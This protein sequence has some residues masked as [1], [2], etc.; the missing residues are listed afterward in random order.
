MTLSINLPFESQIIL[1]SVI[2]VFRSVYNIY[3]GASL[4]N[5]LTTEYVKTVISAK[6]SIKSVFA[7]SQIHLCESYLF[8]RAFQD[9]HIKHLRLLL[10]KN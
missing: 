7:G 1:I 3:N 5:N 6:L 4:R 9:A 8:Y 10:C 2:E